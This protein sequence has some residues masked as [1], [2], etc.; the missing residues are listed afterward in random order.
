MRWIRK[1][2]CTINIWL[3][4]ITFF[5]LAFSVVYG[6]WLTKIPSA[7]Q[8]ADTMGEIINGV[9][10][11]IIAGYIVYV[12]TV[13]LPRMR[14]KYTSESIVMF[15]IELMFECKNDILKNLQRE[16]NFNFSNEF[17]TEEDWNQ[18]KKQSVV[19]QCDWVKVVEDYTKQLTP[20]F[21]KIYLFHDYYW[22]LI[23]PVVYIEHR[24]ISGM[25][26]SNYS[27]R[28]ND[29]KTINVDSVK[30]FLELYKCLK[31]NGSSKEN[32]FILSIKDIQKSDKTTEE[33]YF[34]LSI[35]NYQR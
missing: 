25:L 21:N 2:I 16:R 9:A 32:A 35:K 10:Y 23:K 5:A 11:S 30:D 17:P 24:L 14:N 20:Y 28:N 31:G 34:K 19:Q 1:Y 12:L 15:A 22:D 6:I 27:T 3:N 4:I 7:F 29:D 26:L 18:Y 33:L 8:G 13:H